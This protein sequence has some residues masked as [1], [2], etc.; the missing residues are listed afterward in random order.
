MS[1]RNSIF[2]SPLRR[3]ST[4]STKKNDGNEINKN[5]AINCQ[6]FFDTT[7]HHWWN[8]DNF[9]KSGC[10][11]IQHCSF[12]DNKVS[13]FTP[14]SLSQWIQNQVNRITESTLSNMTIKKRTSFYVYKHCLCE[15][16]QF[17]C[18]FNIYLVYFISPLNFRA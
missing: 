16:S 13:G 3:W 5:K 14:Y 7:L 17:K 15:Y 8:N 10:K 9:T 18:M 6:A 11:K 1:T 4:H 2:D 12:C